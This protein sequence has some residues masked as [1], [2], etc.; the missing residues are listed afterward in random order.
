MAGTAFPTRVIIAEQLTTETILGLDFLTERGC[1]I[2]VGDG[3]LT[4]PRLG[5]SL[6]MNHRPPRS[7]A[8]SQT[9]V[10][11][12]ETV[13]LAAHSEMET[14]AATQTDVSDGNWI[15]EGEH[16]EKVHVPVMV[17][18][19]V[20]CPSQG[21][22]TVRLL[23]PGPEPTVVYSG[24]RIAR[25]EFVETPDIDEDDSACVAV[26]EDE[27]STVPDTKQQFIWQAV[28]E[29]DNLD[30]MQHETLYYLLLSYA[31]VFAADKTDYRRMN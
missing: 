13:Q 30:G 21:K 15:L 16:R 29:S 1:T 5:L 23:N 24:M 19:A 4:F 31:D 8:P 18:R 6:P 26:V 7:S 3:V 14:M 2:Q 20:V 11:L 12:V 22:L 9:Y 25:L 10:T 28:E 27:P 17:A